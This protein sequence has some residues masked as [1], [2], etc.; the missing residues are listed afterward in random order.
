M[1]YYIESTR[2][3]GINPQLILINKVYN[4]AAL[5]LVMSANARIR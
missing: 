5:S 1:L 2:S 3:V 4:K